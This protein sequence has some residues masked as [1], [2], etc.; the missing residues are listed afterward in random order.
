MEDFRKACEKCVLMQGRTVFKDHVNWG[1]FCMYN[2]Y[3]RD[4]SPELI[5]KLTECPKISEKNTS[6]L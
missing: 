2:A 3:T 5:S 1:P 4:F 6:S